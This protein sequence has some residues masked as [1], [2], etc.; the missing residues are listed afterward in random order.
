MGSIILVVLMV[1]WA[2]VF[3]LGIWT[4]VKNKRAGDSILAPVLMIIMSS[5]FFIVNLLEL[6]QKTGS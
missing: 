5:C 1:F 6:L 2:F 4:A 3:G